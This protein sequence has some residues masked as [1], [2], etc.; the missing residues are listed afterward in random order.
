MIYEQLHTLVRDICEVGLKDYEH[1]MF[2]PVMKNTVRAL[3]KLNMIVLPTIRTYEL[4]VSDTLSLFL[5][6]ESIMPLK[7][8]FCKG[9]TVYQVFINDEICAEHGD[10]HCTC[11]EDK[12]KATELE[13]EVATDYRCSF[14]TFYYNDPRG[15]YPF[16]EQYDVRP[17]LHQAGTFV[18]N[19]VTDK[20]SL[21]SGSLLDVGDKLLVT[22]RVDTTSSDEES[23]LV[24]KT[25]WDVLLYKNKEIF[26]KNSLNKEAYYRKMYEREYNFL[27]KFYRSRSKEE[28]EAAFL[29]I[30]MSGPR[31]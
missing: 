12:K 16:S 6:E 20:I 4:E 1:R 9:D 30:R 2:M 25:A 5:P 21:S 31:R 8:G 29:G 13:Q 7:A 3:R 22:C 17:G 18:H 11:E 19:P 14:C 27:K 23:T 28:W 26:G 24:P 10:A 15:G